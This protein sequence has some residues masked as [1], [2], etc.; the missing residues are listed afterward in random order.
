M[1]V[2]FLT[3]IFLTA[4]YS[5]LI[6]NRICANSSPGDLIIVWLIRPLLPD[7][8][9][10]CMLIACRFE[11]GGFLNWGFK[12]DGAVISDCARVGHLFFIFPVY[13]YNPVFVFLTANLLVIVLSVQV[14]WLLDRDIIGFIFLLLLFYLSFF[15]YLYDCPIPI[16]DSFFPYPSFVPYFYDCP[17]LINDFF[18]PYPSLMFCIHIVFLITHISTYVSQLH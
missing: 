2:D 8:A 7:L 15:P 16:N 6:D 11:V 5:F 4:V 10:N 18:F 9:S 3:Q 14:F 13:I 1:S 12:L 17:I